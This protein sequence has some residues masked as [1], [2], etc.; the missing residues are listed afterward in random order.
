MEGSHNTTA[1]TS[2]EQPAGQ[3]VHITGNIV[4]IVRTP[5]GDTPE[6]HEASSWEGWEADMQTEETTR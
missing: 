5:A 6:I 3:D 4:G 2:K 1:D